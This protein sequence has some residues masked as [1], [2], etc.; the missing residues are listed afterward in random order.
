M[1]TNPPPPPRGASAVADFSTYSVNQGAVKTWVT[2]TV[3]TVKAKTT[4]PV[5][6]SQILISDQYHPASSSNGDY[7]G[8]GVDSYDIHVYNDAGTLP[9]A[10]GLGLDKPVVLGEFGE[11]TAQ[12]DAHQATVVQNFLTNAKNGGYAGAWYWSLGGPRTPFSPLFL[13]L[14][15]L[16][17]T[18]GLQGTTARANKT[19]PTHAP[20]ARSNT[21][22]TTAKAT[23]DRLGRRLRILHRCPD[24]PP[25]RGVLVFQGAKGV[26]ENDE[27]MGKRRKGE[28]KW[29]RWTKRGDSVRNMNRLWGA[30]LLGMTKKTNGN[31]LNG[32]LGCPVPPG[33]PLLFLTGAK[34]SELSAWSGRLP[35]RVPTAP[36]ALP[37]HARC[38]RRGSPRRTKGM[39][40]GTHWGPGQTTAHGRGQ[41]F[42]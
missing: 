28:Q 34:L 33:P 18:L 16:P 37:V 6:V 24:P 10:A 26:R 3:K 5:S 20:T 2:N 32:T 9:T 11:S 38:D 7:I 30:L 1:L 36:H 17:L 22:S 14:T 13:P 40:E 29:G 25:A 19:Q 23:A 35:V 4:K 39:R 41:T 8:T 12:G 31:R 27:K 15:P 21:R 42:R